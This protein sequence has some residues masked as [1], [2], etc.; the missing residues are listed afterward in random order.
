MRKRSIT[1]VLLMCA[2]SVMGCESDRV[3]DPGVVK[4][5]PPAPEPRVLTEVRIRP[6]PILLLPGMTVQL[7]V[8][9]WDQHGRELTWR[10]DATTY[11]SSNPAIVTVSNSGIVTAVS[12]GRAVI[13]TTLTLEGVSAT[14]SVITDVLEVRPGNYQLTAPITESGWGVS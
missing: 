12:P 4:P 5:P 8:A 14:G 9:A 7:T 6:A 2:A 11:S 13:S 3:V 1:F 10:A